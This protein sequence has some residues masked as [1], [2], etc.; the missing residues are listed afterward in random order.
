MKSLLLAW[1]I[2]VAL[3]LPPCPPN[4]CLC[5]HK[6]LHLFVSQPAVG[7]KNPM[8]MMMRILL[9][10]HSPPCLLSSSL[11]LN[12]SSTCH[13]VLTGMMITKIMPPCHRVLTGMIMM[14][15]PRKMHIVQ[16]VIVYFFFTCSLFPDDQ[17][18]STA[19]VNQVGPRTLLS[20]WCP[21]TTPEKWHPDYSTAWSNGGCTLKADCDSPGYSTQVNCCNGSFGGQVSGACIKGLPN[22]PTLSPT[23]VSTK[24]YADQ[25]I[26]WST[27]GC[28]NTT[29]LP[30]YATVF[31]DTQ[32]AC[33]KGSFGGQLSGACIKGLP[34][35]PTLSPTTVESAAGMWYADQG[36]AWS[37]GGCKNTT[38]HPIYATAFFDS[39]LLCCKG[40]FGGQLS[41]ACIKGLP[42]PPTKSPILKLS[43]KP[44]LESGLILNPIANPN[45]SKPTTSTPTESPTASP[46]ASPTQ[47]PT[48]S[49]T[50]SP[51]ASPTQSPTE[52]PTASPTASPSL[53]PNETP[54]AGTTG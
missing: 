47:S 3:I 43:P 1:Q 53:P 20:P 36:G 25:G 4:V 52:S 19:S 5:L 22:P 24:W 46:T 21:S 27:G 34:N 41:G 51:T 9:L 14:I 42:N 29:P 13:R 54:T 8:M 17:Y 50:A 10:K 15:M 45:T 48:E 26:A 6:V 28:K 33:C 37:T 35:P 40:S 30:I 38:P 44:N 12:H 16:I 18:P 32:L 49:P 2:Q 11:L 7:R 39:Q 31:F 23:T